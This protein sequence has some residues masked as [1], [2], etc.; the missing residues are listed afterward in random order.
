MLSV[1]ILV[2]NKSK[3]CSMLACI[4]GWG[5]KRWTADTNT[6]RQRLVISVESAHSSEDIIDRVQV[7]ASVAKLNPPNVPRPTTPIKARTR[8][9]QTALSQAT[10]SC[11]RRPRAL[12][13]QSIL[14][15]NPSYDCASTSGSLTWRV[16][17]S[18][19]GRTAMPRCALEC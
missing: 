13:T 11:I 10:N 19:V 8:R 9:S 14:D 18:A 15:A 12:L 4:E 1:I 17:F 2:A 3:G 7:G 16:Y 5:R 6:G